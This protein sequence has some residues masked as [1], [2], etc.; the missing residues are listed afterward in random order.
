LSNI[1][2]TPHHGGGWE[3]MVK[4]FKRIVAKAANSVTKLTCDTFAMLLIRAKGIVNQH[5]ITINGN[6]CIITL[7]QLLQPACPAAVGFKVG[8]PPC[9]EWAADWAVSNAEKPWA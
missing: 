9:L 6:L 2:Y 8:Q 7:M 3:R 5:P 4:E 1:K